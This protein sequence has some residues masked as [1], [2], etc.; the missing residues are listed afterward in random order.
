MIIGTEAC[1]EGCEAVPALAETTL[2]HRKLKLLL[3]SARTSHLVADAFSVSNFPFLNGWIF[4]YA[5]MAICIIV[6]RIPLTPI[7]VSINLGRFGFQFTS[8]AEIFQ[9]TWLIITT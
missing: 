1:G 5:M 7:P 4:Y 6:L 2:G 9:F 8:N 3:L